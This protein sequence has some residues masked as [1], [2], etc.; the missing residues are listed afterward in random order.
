MSHGLNCPSINGDNGD[1]DTGQEKRGQLVDILDSHENDHSH[2]CEADG[3]IH[4]H[5]VQ[6]ST[7]RPQGIC[8][9]KDGRLGH[10]IFLK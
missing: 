1:N 5:V 9:M 6:Q 3:T 8:G 2:Q 7:V 4:S 10:Q